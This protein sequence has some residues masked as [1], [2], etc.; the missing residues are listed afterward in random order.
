M[1]IVIT[2]S[3]YTLIRRFNLIESEFE[4]R[5]K[6]EDPCDHDSFDFYFNWVSYRTEDTVV[7]KME[8][9]E[10]LKLNLEKS[11]KLR[12]SI[13]TFIY[14]KFSDVAKKYYNYYKR[15]HCPNK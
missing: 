13:K 15:I 2:E 6:T 10:N 5:L 8:E 7:Y 9:N 11:R 4:H 3:Q 1:K 14:H 12:E